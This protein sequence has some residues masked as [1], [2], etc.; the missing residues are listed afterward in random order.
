MS[1]ESIVLTRE[2]LYEA[3]WKGTIKSIAAEYGTSAAE[4]VRACDELD[5]PRP[6]AGH[7]SRV[8]LGY[9]EEPPPLP[10]PT[11]DVPSTVS[12]RKREPPSTAPRRAP[13]VVRTSPHGKLHPVAKAIDSAIEGHTD[14]RDGTLKLR[15][16]GCAVL[17]VSKE[18]RRR[19]I[20]IFDALFKACDENRYKIH[21]AP[22]PQYGP[23]ELK[24][25]SQGEEIGIGVSERITQTDH[26]LTP[27][28]I[29]EKK[30]GGYS[31]APKY[32]YTPTGRLT[33][34]LNARYRALKRNSFADGTGRKLEDVLG[35]VVL[36]L[37]DGF[38]SLVRM[39]QEDQVVAE[40]Q[41]EEQERR[42]REQRR[43]E[44]RKALVQDLREMA[45]QWR[46]AQELRAFLH[47]VNERIPDQERTG[48]VL[49]WL[50][51][52][53]SAVDELDPLAAIERVPKRLDLE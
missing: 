42:A 9:L 29:A 22:P 51:W 53:R 28:E 2:Q 31:W 15:G 34:S 21:F 32:D 47:A 6:A 3:V 23:Y 40:R 50:E 14:V 13:P 27:K 52:A 37:Q 10:P 8:A 24:I 25:R 1:D 17:K 44:H 4:L 18:H 43:A 33:V 35:S 5:V 45:G 7:W 39:R 41:R 19:A 20:L 46:E 11:G 36:A 30:G 16:Y 12:L 49:E 38:A 48:G 26:K